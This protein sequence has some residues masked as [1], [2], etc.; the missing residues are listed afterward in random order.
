MSQYRKAKRSDLTKFLIF[1]GIYVAVI[2]TTAFFLLPTYWIVWFALIVCGLSLL[3]LWDKKST[4]YQCPKC[5]NQ[6]E[7]SFLI[8]FISP[9]GVTKNRV[10][11]K[12]LKCPKCQNRSKMEILV[13]R[14]RDKPN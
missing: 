4:A 14:Q 8:D 12:Y 5:G 7:I 13:K 10:Y 1:I 3:V 9:H 2:S 6:F 11:W